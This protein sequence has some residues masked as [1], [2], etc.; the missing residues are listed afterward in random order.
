MPLHR[1]ADV[2]ATL[3][4]AATSRA[5]L[6]FHRSLPGYGPTAL[7]DLPALAR[8]CGV[9]RVWLKDESGRFGLPAFKVLGAS[10]AVCST[11]A[12]RLGEPAL[13][14]EPRAL[15]ARL[16]GAPALMAATDGNH[17]RAVARTAAL[18]G[19]PARIFVPAGAAPAR[20][21]AI[22]GEGAAV[23]EVDG[24][25]D[26]AVER[27][28]AVAAAE[29]ALLVQDTGWPARGTDDRGY[30]EIPRR[31]AE[32]YSTLL[33][34]CEEQL[35]AAGEGPPDAML[36]QVGV[37]ALAEAA[38]RFWKR[39]AV[40]GS[41]R[42]VGVQPAAAACL[43]AALAAGGPVR[44]PGRQ[45][46][47]MAGLNCGTVSSVAWPWLR[48]GLDA[49]VTVEDDRAAEAMRALAAEG[50]VAGETGAAG[51]AGLLELAAGGGAAA[52]GLG[53]ASRVLLLSTEGAT[54]P[55][56]WRRIVGRSAAG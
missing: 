55:E 56:S 29:G 44:L 3:P 53:A 26:D 23:E 8:R 40:G 5:P 22:A 38:V 15:R 54:D 51:A 25:Y 43:V 18:L 37:G 7:R 46:S 27:S 11:L 32:G 45:E 50:V 41:V 12:E 20:L 17:G 4:D 1:N 39:P 52:V 28:A 14:A 13:A 47:L 9:G 48:R 33:W 34:E 21:A 19:L 31:V 2:E 6:A 49:V 24:T 30:E 36:V 42:L 16:N 35:A 10:W